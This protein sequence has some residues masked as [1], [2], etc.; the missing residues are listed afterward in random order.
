MPSS[1]SAQTKEKSKVGSARRLSSPLSR[2]LTVAAAACSV[3][4]GA[5]FLGAVSPLPRLDQAQS[6]SSLP[7]MQPHSAIWISTAS[8]T[9]YRA[10]GD[11]QRLPA[12]ARSPIALASSRSAPRHTLS[13]PSVVH[14]C[15]AVW[16]ECILCE[17]SEEEGL[18]GGGSHAG[19]VSVMQKGSA[20]HSL[21]LT[22][23]RADTLEM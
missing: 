10:A 14:C 22:R 13:R 9:L 21:K 23:C 3:P 12:H 6:R 16:H 8:S 17:A 19:S 11:Q 15:T 4:F 5:W 2:V 7:Y 20:D 18:L 1:V